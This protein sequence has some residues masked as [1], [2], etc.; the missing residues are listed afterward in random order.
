[1]NGKEKNYLKE[2]LDERKELQDQRHQENLV[3][4]KAMEDKM[5]CGV[6]TERMNSQDKGIIGLK[7]IFGI[8]ILV[9]LA[10]LGVV[11]VK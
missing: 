4:L 7:W 8:V 2:L 6:H 9:F 3:R 1:M 5:V 10:V 11:L